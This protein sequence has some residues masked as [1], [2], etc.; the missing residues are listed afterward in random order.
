LS[1]A[2]AS[3]STLPLPIKGGIQPFG[4]GSEVFHVF[5][6]GQGNEPSTI[7]NFHGFVGLANVSGTGTGTKKKTGESKELV[8]DADCRFMQGT[9]VGRDRL[10][11]TGTF[12]FI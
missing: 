10:V 3:N 9:Y 12:G 7:R 8:F 4:P 11:H 6:P 1:R 5:L 2:W